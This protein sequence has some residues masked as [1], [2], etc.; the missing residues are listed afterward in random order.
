MKLFRTSIWTWWDI[1]TLK[2]CCTLFGAIIGAYFHTFVLQY[3]WI[4]LIMAII[5]GIRSA[6][7]YFRD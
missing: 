6:I 4:I 1:G 3:L 2:G 7:V 5:L